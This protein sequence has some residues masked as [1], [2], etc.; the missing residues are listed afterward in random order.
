MPL[1]EYKC[2]NEK[3]GMTTEIKRDAD[4]RDR[5]LVCGRCHSQMC[6]IISLTA[7]PRFQGKDWT[8]QFYR[9]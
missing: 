8:P 2:L 5:R 6:R 1:Y 4:A 7:E 3:C 9:K